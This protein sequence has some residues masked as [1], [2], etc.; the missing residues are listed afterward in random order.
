MLG[1]SRGRKNDVAVPTS[2]PEL[3]M[4]PE[5]S[6]MLARLVTYHPDTFPVAPPPP[7]K[8]V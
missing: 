6:W 2:H 8:T 3:E 5:A 4:E 7:D 1:E